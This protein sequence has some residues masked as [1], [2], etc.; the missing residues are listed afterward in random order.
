MQLM[1]SKLEA[2]LAIEGKFSQDG[3]LAMTQGEDMATEMARALTEGLEV[4]GVEQV[5]SK[6]NQ[7]NAPGYRGKPAPEG[8]LF[9]VD[10]ENYVKRKIPRRRRRKKSPAELGQLSLF[11][12]L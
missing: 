6:L 2:S 8:M 3:L 1:G 9:Y 11:G 10:P 4:E 5:W 12:D 7:G